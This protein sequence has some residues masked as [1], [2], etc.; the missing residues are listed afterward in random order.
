MT[1][2][3]IAGE[4]RS[5]VA[6]YLDVSID[7]RERPRIEVTNPAQSDQPAT[8]KRRIF[9]YE[10]HLKFKLP[11]NFSSSWK[12]PSGKSHRPMWKHANTSAI[13]GFSTT[14]NRQSKKRYK[15]F[16]W[17]VT[18]DAER[19]FSWCIESAVIRQT[20]NLKLWSEAFSDEIYE[21]ISCQ[22]DG[23][24]AWP[25]DLSHSSQLSDEMRCQTPN[26]M[27]WL[28]AWRLCVSA[29]G[30]PLTRVDSSLL[31]NIQV[32]VFRPLAQWSKTTSD[33]S[34][35]YYNFINVIGQVVRH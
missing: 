4:N 9:S 32:T 23:E 14:T 1:W 11:I 29:S 27:L 13:V 2:K 15:L 6:K 21:T 31:L 3:S 10:C 26:K 7:D 16:D 25:L 17:H 35:L 18:A 28:T 19:E 33:V 24:S 30:N 5:R 12:S 20:W 34:S 22:M 8:T